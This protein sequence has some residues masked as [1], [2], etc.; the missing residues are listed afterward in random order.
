VSKPLTAAIYARVSTE[1]QDNTLQFHELHEYAR[2]QGWA[3]TEY[4][5]K[6]SSAKRRP[7]F[8]RLMSDAKARKFD[9][10]IVW[11]LDRMCRSM[12]QFTETMLTLDHANVRFVCV[13][14]GIDTDRRSPTTE[15]LMNILAA[16]AQLERSMIVERVRAGVAEAKRRGKHCG[17]PKK[18]FRRDEALEMRAGGA[19]LRDIAKALNASL[20][21][22]VR[23]LKAQ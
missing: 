21:T 19:S 5:E 12:K 4:A 9:I 7:V 20:T 13:T 6:A 22:V 14:Q 11:K 2:R 8:D 10:I 15:F 18:I 1:D 17:R 23:A 3:T 16:V